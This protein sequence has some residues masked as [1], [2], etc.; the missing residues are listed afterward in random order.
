MTEISANPPEKTPALTDIFGPLN[1]RL[2][3]GLLRLSTEGRASTEDAIQLVHLALDQG[4]RILDTADSYCLDNGDFHYGE[5]LA[6]A[7]AESWNG[8]REEIRILTKVG[9]VRPAGKWLPNGTPKH[10]RQSVDSSLLELKTDQLFLLQLHAK[11]SRVPFEDTLSALVELQKSGKVKHLGLCNV[12]PAEVRQAMRHFSVASVQCELS[13]LTRK[14]AFEGMLL[15]TQQLGIPF[16]AHRPLGGYAKVE[17]LGKNRVLVPLADRHQ[18]TPFEIA[19]AAVLNA[20]PNVIPLIGATKQTSLLS[21]LKATKLSLDISDRTALS[22]KYAFDAAPDAA[23]AISPPS[24]PSTLPQLFANQG[25]ADS[26]EIVLLMGIQGAGK[27]ELVQSYVD[28]GYARLN[29]DLA[30]GKVDDLNGQ[31][32]QLL[33][34]GQ[35]RIVLDNTYPTRVSRAPI[36]RL[37]HAAGV[38]VRCRFLDTTIEDARI[39]IVHRILDRYERLLGPSEM[40]ELAKVD[41][42][43]P[44]PIAMQRWRDSLERPEWDEGFSAIDLIPFVRRMPRDHSGKGLLLDV[45]GTLRTTLSGEIYPR[46]ADDVV[47]LPN[48]RETLSRWIDQG[49]SLFF[50]SNQSGIASGKLSQGDADSAFARTVELLGL[51]VTEITYCP[52][53]AFPVGCFCRKPL[54]GIGVYLSRKYKLDPAHLVM[55][56]DMDSDAAFAVSVGARYFDSKD[57][58]E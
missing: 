57:F 46:H 17:K 47:L 13:V 15:L 2:G 14:S 31:L 3:L 44:P 35:N 28:R 26:P 33:A 10:I 53:P 41:Q 45:D 20:A 5:T 24:K 43:L 54:P 49:Y 55:V 52:H 23:D 22:I 19:L 6:R 56:G 32:Q 29:R 21:S 50:V 1:V 37:A 8:P 11:D 7:A 51:P 34:E 39:N 18:A 42:N 9:L 27:S 58:F 25:P 12:G 30:G 16:L 4:V 38:P 48:R 36:V 40:K